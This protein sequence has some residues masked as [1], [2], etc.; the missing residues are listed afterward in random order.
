M[1][2]PA[3]I[4]E[5]S[6]EASCTSSRTRDKFPSW[7]QAAQM[8][9]EMKRNNES[10][11]ASQRIHVHVGTHV[12]PPNSKICLWDPGVPD[13]GVLGQ[14]LPSGSAAWLARLAFWRDRLVGNAPGG[15]WAS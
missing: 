8:E 2:L 15:A 7:T 6:R 5:A 10:T 11:S 9:A 13:A 3:A 1:V 14:A 4:K 12:L